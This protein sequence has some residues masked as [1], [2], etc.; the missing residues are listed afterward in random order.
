MGAAIIIGSLAFMVLLH[1]LSHYLMARAYGFKTPVFGL[2]MPVGPY[3][4]V[5]RAWQT[6]FRLHLLL[7]GGYVEIP[8]LLYKE[9]DKTSSPEADYKEFPLAQKLVVAL[10]G[11]VFYFVAAWIISF[12]AAMTIGEP[13]ANWW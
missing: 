7:I 3:L 8:E 1:E 2:G 13:I 9:R 4:V 12:T 5:G 10:T 6:E 11:V